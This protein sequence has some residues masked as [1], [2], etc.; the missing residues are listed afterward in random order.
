M[1]RMMSSRRQTRDLTAPIRNVRH[2]Y[3]DFEIAERATCN[4]DR[5]TCNSVFEGCIHI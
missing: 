3:Q 1:A 4:N 5:V 2:A